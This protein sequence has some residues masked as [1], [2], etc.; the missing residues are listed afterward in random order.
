MTIEDDV[1]VW[2]SCHPDYHRFRL[3]ELT[4]IAQILGVQPERLWERPSHDKS[5]I[6]G[7]EVPWSGDQIQNCSREKI[8]KYAEN[9]SEAAITLGDDDSV[10]VF[11][12]IDSNIQER[13][14]KEIVNRSV[15]TKGIAKVKEFYIV[16]DHTAIRF[17]FNLHGILYLCI[18]GLLWSTFMAS[19]FFFGFTQIWTHGP[20]YE[21]IIQTLKSTPH[22]KI[23]QYI[24]PSKTF[25]FLVDT[26]GHHLTQKQQIDR[27]GNFTFLFSGKERADLKNPDVQLVLFVL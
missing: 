23:H 18:F 25:S 19:C 24:N 16:N 21:S 4:S 7:I 5:A 27:M 14:A 1:L 22:S 12:R 8:I 10:F 13:V 9:G 11:V 6:P 15:L 3:A 17:S 26:F 2:F 20:S